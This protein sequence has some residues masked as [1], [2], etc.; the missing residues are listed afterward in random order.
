MSVEEADDAVAS[1]DEGV[2]GRSA[3]DGNELDS[4]TD[5]PGTESVTDATGLGNEY[6]ASYKI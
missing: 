6:V 2:R 5:R 4:D 1:V 3:Y